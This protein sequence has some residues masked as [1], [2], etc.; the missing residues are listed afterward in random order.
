MT[1]L[2]LGVELC[3]FPAMNSELDKFDLKLLDA[4]QRNSRLTA[5]QLAEKVC[6]SPRQCSVG[7][8]DCVSTKSSKRR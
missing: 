1:E 3:R 7:F 5:D 2:R 4:V 8:G 6:L